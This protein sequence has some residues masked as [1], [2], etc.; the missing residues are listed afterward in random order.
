MNNDI[1]LIYLCHDDKYKNRYNNL[2]QTISNKI[3]C[4]YYNPDWN[5]IKNIYGKYMYKT[6]GKDYIGNT[7]FAIIFFKNFIQPDYKYYIIMEYDC[8]YTGD[9]NDIVDIFIEKLPYNDIIY[10]DNYIY[11]T[12]YDWY[13]TRIDKYKIY[14]DII[15]QMLFNIYAMSDKSLDIIEDAYKTDN[16]YGHHELI[17]PAIVNKYNLKYDC[18]SN[19]ITT[20]LKVYSNELP[21]KIYKNVLYHPIKDNNYT[22]EASP[23]GL[24][25]S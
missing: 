5:N 10:Q 24:E 20:V 22:L 18:L 23:V 1:C 11:H 3:D 16:I 8:I 15:V 2:E 19:Y 7:I 12:K 6:K 4:Y 14:T 9:Y 13:W 21:N 17:I 25:T